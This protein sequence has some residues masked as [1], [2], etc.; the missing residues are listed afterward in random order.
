MNDDRIIT[1]KNRVFDKDGLGLGK[2]NPIS[3]HTV[4]TSVYRNT[5]YN[6][7]EDII[8]SGFVRPKIGKL[9]GGHENE[10]FW[11]IGGEKTYYYDKRVVLE[12]PISIVYDGKVGAISIN[13]L[14]AIW[15]F[16]EKQNKY[17]NKL[18]QIKTLHIDNNYQRSDD[19]KQKSI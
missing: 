17:I 14:S 12:A 11:S 4:G 13:D 19:V 18:E 5:G 15:I 8:E 10:V 16:D 6:Q 2:N 1:A 9:R 7:L 3:L